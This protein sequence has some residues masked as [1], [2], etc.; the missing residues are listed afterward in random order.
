MIARANVLTD[1]AR[2][3]AV[4]ARPPELPAPSVRALLYALERLGY[5]TEALLVEAGASRFAWDDADS[6]IPCAA[7]GEI[8]A[9]AMRHRPM[10][11]LG[12]RLAAETPMGA[13]RLVDYL[14]LTSETAG[15][16]LT[17]LSRYLRLT[18]APYF[19]NPRAEEDPI[20]V[21]FERPVSAFA[22]EYGIT[23]TILHL[24]RETGGRLAAQSVSLCQAPDC[25]A[26]MEEML[27]CPIQANASWDGFQ[28]LREMWH[29]P[30]QRRDAVL[31]GI[32]EQQAG[33]IPE[34]SPRPAS[35]AD[36][37]A[38]L[39]RSRMAKGDAQIQLL[40]K[41]LSTSARSLQRRL[42][43]EGVSFHAVLDRVRREAATEYLSDPKLSAG[44]VAYLLGYSEPAAFHR[45]FK[46][47]NGMTPQAYRSETR[48]KDGREPEVAGPV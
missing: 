28:M 4:D 2:S 45:A 33:G 47:W 14:A 32:L 9:A 40:A 42:A 44:E 13:Y 25:A 20:R 46:R 16:A 10:R 23:L 41:A 18:G 3:A 21:V 37:V 36:E 26:E 43:G 5:P 29:L 15:A 22:A 31:R 19:L 24:R 1:R 12:A 39:L 11:N 30:M 48:R 7:V 17:Q 8:F 38:R 27:G 6:L 35:F 34:E